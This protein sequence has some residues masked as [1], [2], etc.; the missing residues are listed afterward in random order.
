MSIHPPSRVTALPLAKTTAKI[1]NKLLIKELSHSPTLG[2]FSV[3]VKP[4]PAPA[5]RFRLR[6]SRLQRAVVRHIR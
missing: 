4:L 1:L 6:G 2:Q 3:S 5:D